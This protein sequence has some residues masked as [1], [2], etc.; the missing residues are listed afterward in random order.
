MAQSYTR[1]PDVGSV[2]FSDVRLSY[3]GL[4]FF[5]SKGNQLVHQA[6]LGFRFP[7]PIKTGQVIND[8]ITPPL[9]LYAEKKVRLHN[10][11]H[12][13]IARLYAP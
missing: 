13:Q 11:S 7:L 9:P 10:Q 1:H 4:T 2:P 5:I 6:N 12:H 3:A 8:Y